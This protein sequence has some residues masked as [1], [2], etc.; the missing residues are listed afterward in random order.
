VIVDLPTGVVKTITFVNSDVLFTDDRQ[1]G[2]GLQADIMNKGLTVTGHS[3]GG[4]LASAFTRLFPETGA[5][6]L[7][8]NGAGFG[9]IGVNGFSAANVNHVFSMLY[10]SAAFDPSRIHNLY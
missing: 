1:T 7:T 8:I 5:E 9:K 10:G 3:L 6:A 4:H 2:L